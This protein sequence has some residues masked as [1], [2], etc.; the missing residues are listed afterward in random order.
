ME[1]VEEQRLEWPRWRDSDHIVVNHRYPDQEVL[2]YATLI[3]RGTP[4][5]TITGR[6]CCWSHCHVS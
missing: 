3:H 1:M 5:Q 2:V 6:Q 4:V